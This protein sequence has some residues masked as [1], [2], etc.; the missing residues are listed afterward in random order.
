[1]GCSQRDSDCFD[2]EKPAHAVTLS[3]GFWLG[4]T[5][6]TVAA[7]EMFVRATGASM[8]GVQGGDRY[9]VVNVTWVESQS[10]C[11]WAGGRLPT[12]AEW[13]YAARGGVAEARYG[14]LDS[15]AWYSGNSSSSLHEVATKQPNRYGLYDMMGNVFV[16]ASDWYDENYYRIS[17]AID[18][19]GPPGPSDFHN[20]KV[21][22]G[23]NY[24]LDE[25]YARAFRRLRH[26]FSERRSSAG[27]LRCVWG[28]SS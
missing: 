3:K 6:V 13:E 7:Y 15:V 5:D 28:G 4:Q 16:W 21:L 12:E 26:E 25:N 17:P 27:G 8:P 19:Q 10:Y 23:G 20:Y 14:P 11:Q 18:P 2:S 22:R 1:M 9:P 24:G